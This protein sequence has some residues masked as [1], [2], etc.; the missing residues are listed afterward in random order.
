MPWNLVAGFS[1]L[2]DL[3]PDEQLRSQQTVIRQIASGPPEDG[4]YVES[5]V[6]VGNVGGENRDAEQLS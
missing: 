6:E 3:G 2:K 1:N 5:G 4:F